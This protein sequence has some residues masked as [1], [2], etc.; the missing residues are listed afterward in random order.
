MQSKVM[1]RVSLA[2]RTFAKGKSMLPEEANSQRESPQGPLA[3]KEPTQADRNNDAEIA[4]P[5]VHHSILAVLL[6][7]QKPRRVLSIELNTNYILLETAVQ[8]ESGY[9]G[10]VRVVGFWR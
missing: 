4:G 9:K 5:G 8:K 6:N 7:D 10:E 1:I 3:V 2:K